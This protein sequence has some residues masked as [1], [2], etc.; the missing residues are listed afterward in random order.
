MGFK[1]V[2]QKALWEDAGMVSIEQL[3][4]D[5]KGYVVVHKLR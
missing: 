4:N 3:I 2:L 5:A 1:E